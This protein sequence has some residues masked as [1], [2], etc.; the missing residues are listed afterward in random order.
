MG[1]QAFVGLAMWASL[2]ASLTP[3]LAQF[4]SYPSR[5]IR[6]VVGFPPG[7]GIDVVARLFAER[8]SALLQQTV[9]VENRGGAAGALAGKQVATAAPDGYTILA[10]SNSMIINQI[11]HPKSGLDVER[12]LYPIASV[13]RQAFIIVAAPDFKVGSLEEVFE[14][15]RRQPLLY[16]TPGAGSIPHLLV[17][18]ILA[19]NPGVQAT[20]VPYQGAA[21][22]LRAAVANHIHVAATTLPPAVPL[23]ADGKLQALAVTTPTRSPVL[24]QVPTTGE[25]GFPAILGAA[26]AGIFVPART[27]PQVVERLEETILNVSEMPDIKTRLNQL[28]FE[29]VIL[30]GNQFRQ[31]ISDEIRNWTD[32]VAKSSLRPR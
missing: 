11:L 31:Y 25:A 27:P 22:A 23:I 1:A 12:E 9:F 15:A 19:A 8:M 18:Q 3:A 7:G 16:G 17:E 5:N 26:W 21:G 30:P 4:D 24:P 13:A 14:F 6:M 28:G 2:W 32:V 29:A 10:G 20:H